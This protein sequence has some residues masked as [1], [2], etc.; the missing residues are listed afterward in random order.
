MTPHTEIPARSADPAEV[1]LQAL[2]EWHQD[3]FDRHLRYAH[4]LGLA[5]AHA[6]RFALQPLHAATP[7]PTSA[8]TQ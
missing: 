1:H 7:R 4:S 2:S 3:Q 5:P 6:P 8:P